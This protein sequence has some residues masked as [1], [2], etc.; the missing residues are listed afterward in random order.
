M[1]YLIDTTALGLTDY[2]VLGI[3]LSLFA[4]AIIKLY[5]DNAASKDRLYTQFERL[6]ADMKAEYKEEIKKLQGDLDKETENN[7][8]YRNDD[9]EKMLQTIASSTE[10]IRENTAVNNQLLDYFKHL[11]Y[12][13]K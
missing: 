1:L 5:Y 13:V 10:C 7:R 3:V 4:A 12:P 8:K 9:R 6:T 11:Q 2:G